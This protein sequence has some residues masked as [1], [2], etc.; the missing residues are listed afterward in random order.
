ML[1]CLSVEFRSVA[2]SPKSAH[3]AQTCQ[4]LHSVVLI[5]ARVCV[6][7]VAGLTRP[8]AKAKD[9]GKTYA[10][11]VADTVVVQPGGAAP[12]VVTALVPKGWT[13]A[14]Y[15]FNVRAHHMRSWISELLDTRARISGS[16]P[17]LESVTAQPAQKY[18]HSLILWPTPMPIVCTVGSAA[19]MLFLIRR[20]RM[21]FA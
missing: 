20:R 6:S 16:I 12:E 17:T 5:L 3:G 13:D 21:L 7:G 15:F 8:D 10:L 4:K 11:Q 19:V 1:S 9:A 2:I 14:A 18:R